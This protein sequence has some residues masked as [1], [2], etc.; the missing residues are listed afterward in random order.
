MA[1]RYSALK[2]G[3]WVPKINLSS[4]T[5]HSS[6]SSHN[7]TREIKND[8]HQVVDREQGPRP[9]DK[10]SDVRKGDFTAPGSEGH[11]EGPSSSTHL[12]R[13]TTDNAN[14]PLGQGRDE[15][16]K[17]EET[18]KGHTPPLREEERAEDSVPLV[19]KE[20]HTAGI[21]SKEQ[22][23]EKVQ[24]P[25][26]VTNNGIAVDSRKEFSM[27]VVHVHG[28]SEKPYGERSAIKEERRGQQVAGKRVTISTDTPKEPEGDEQ[29]DKALHGKFTPSSDRSRNNGRESL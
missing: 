18:A 27:G 16:L 8:I 9:D 29:V 25:H 22:E 7:R 6:L 10:A 24:H 11:H 21:G 1:S 3:S 28:S 2:N 19:G 26:S 20:A 15:S 14:D 23:E 12:E 4:D 17:E 5:L 13:E